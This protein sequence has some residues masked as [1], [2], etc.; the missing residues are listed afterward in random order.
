M[1]PQN[2]E[3]FCYVVKAGQSPW[4]VGSFSWSLKMLFGGLRNYFAFFYF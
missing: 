4:R 1:N 3:K 2:D